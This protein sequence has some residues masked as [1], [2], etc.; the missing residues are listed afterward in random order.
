MPPRKR[1]FRE[2]ILKA[3]VDLVRGTGNAGAFGP[4]YCR[5]IKLFHPADLF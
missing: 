4:Q 3:A 2:D 1:I 5:K